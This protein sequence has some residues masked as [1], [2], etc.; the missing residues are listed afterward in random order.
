MTLAAIL[1]PA[2]DV[3]ATYNEALQSEL[4]QRYARSQAR[5]KATPASGEASSR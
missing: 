5:H 3:E 4:D 1:W 2:P